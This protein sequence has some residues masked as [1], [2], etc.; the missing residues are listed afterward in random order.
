MQFAR[1]FAPLKLIDFFADDGYLLESRKVLDRLEDD[2]FR[3]SL[4]MRV[5]SREE[6]RDLW[7]H[8]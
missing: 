1:S 8:A 4:R 2:N 6:G 7:L 5:I 3:L